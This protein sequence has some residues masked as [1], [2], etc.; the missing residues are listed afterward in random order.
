MMSRIRDGSG[1]K[2]PRNLIDLIVEARHAQL[3]SEDRSPREQ[4]QD[5][6]IIEGDAIRRAQRALSERRVQ[7]T[8]FAEA[9]DLVPMIEKFRDGKAE[10]SA[11]S[12][13]D[14]LGFPEHSART[15]IKPLL[16]IGF[17]EEV[18]SSFKI[19]MLYR[20]GLNITQGKAFEAGDAADEE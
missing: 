15:A 9:A 6:P 3:R 8:L 14:L 2:P 20:D 5:I 12:L 11:K 4:S 19:P 1:V 10:H 16:E 17:L 13:S 7:D 18:G